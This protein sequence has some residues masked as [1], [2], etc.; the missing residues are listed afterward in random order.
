LIESPRV[1]SDKHLVVDG[2]HPRLTPDVEPESINSLL[3]DSWSEDGT[4]DQLRVS[5]SSCNG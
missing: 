1:L 4:L 3:V 2:D 5:S